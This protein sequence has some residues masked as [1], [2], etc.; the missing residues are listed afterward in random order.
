MIKLVGSKDESGADVISLKVR[1]IRQD[2]L[3]SHASAK[4]V[5]YVYNAN[6]RLTDTRTAATLFGV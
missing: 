2:T 6:T 1:I 4:H 3:L 5:Q